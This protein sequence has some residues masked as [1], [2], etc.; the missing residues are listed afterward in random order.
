MNVKREE[1]S[2][3]DPTKFWIDVILSVDSLVFSSV[4]GKFGLLLG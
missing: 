3:G 4:E 2:I 1:G